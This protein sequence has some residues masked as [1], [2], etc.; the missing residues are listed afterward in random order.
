M[1]ERAYD[2]ERG[3]LAVMKSCPGWQAQR[4]LNVGTRPR[5]RKGQ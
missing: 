5:R 3:P 1:W 4:T 2:D